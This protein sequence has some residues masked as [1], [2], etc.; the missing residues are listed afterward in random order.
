MVFYLFHCFHYVCA[1]IGIAR[2]SSESSRGGEK[3]A[4]RRFLREGRQY[5]SVAPNFRP[6]LGNQRRL[7][8]LGGP[9]LGRKAVRVEVDL[10]VAKLTSLCDRENSSVKC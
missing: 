10:L 7:R 8:P 5:V 4:R 2:G 3:A 9:V 1:G 6:G